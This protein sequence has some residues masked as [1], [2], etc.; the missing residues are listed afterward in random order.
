MSI[1]GDRKNGMWMVGTVDRV[2]SFYRGKVPK[3]YKNMQES[4][5]TDRMTGSKDRT[6]ENGESS[7]V[8]V[9]GLMVEK[10]LPRCEILRREGRVDGWQRLFPTTLRPYSWSHQ[11][12]CIYTNSFPV[13]SVWNYKH[14]GKRVQPALPNLAKLNEALRHS[15][16]TVQRSGGQHVSCISV[17]VNT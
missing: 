8:G 11:M 7:G 14:S 6:F 4:W 15:S 5:V 12:T 3:K 2:S 1:I 9:R 10:S 16:S 17:S 13:Y